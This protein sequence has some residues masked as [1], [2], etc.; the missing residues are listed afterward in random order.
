MVKMDLKDAYFTITLED[1]SW[2]YTR[3]MWEGNI[4]KFTCMMFGLGP[5]PRI[6]MKIMKIPITS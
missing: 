3:F 2:K 1:K 6:F 4:Y 5:A